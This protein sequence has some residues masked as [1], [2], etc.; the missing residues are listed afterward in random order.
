M[1]LT[2]SFLIIIC[3]S[4]VHSD[5]GYGVVLLYH[6]FGDAR[7]PTT[8]VS[9]ED[10]RFQM[11]YLKRAGFRVVSLGE[12]LGYLKRGRFPG[13]VALITIDDGYKS[14]LK[15]FEVLKEYNYPFLLFLY[16]EA[17]NRYPDFLTLEDVRMML[18]SGLVS[19]GLHSYSHFRLSALP[20]AERESFV[21]R[22]TLKA[23]ARFKKLFGF[24]PKVYSY[25]YGE[26]SRDIVSFISSRFDAAFTQDLG[27]VDNCT[28]PY[29]VPRIPVVG[30]WSRPEVFV[31][32][33]RL[34]PLCIRGYPYGFVPG[35]LRLRLGLP[36]GFRNCY[37][38]ATHTGWRRMERASEVTLN[39]TGKERIGVKCIKDGMV[40][41]RLWLVM[42]E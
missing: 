4:P 9:I 17:F 15:A 20:S 8:S 19:L 14:T 40:Y 30:S 23:L 28:S 10:F 34:R 21:E 22:D 32:L 7:Y 16:M 6:R 13:K 3:A 38:Y 12:F 29:L 11:E 26:Y 36:H 2:I 37:L 42:P 39:I 5:T 41:Q 35:R 27:T 33:L 24:Y 1:I 31:R 18:K 25:P